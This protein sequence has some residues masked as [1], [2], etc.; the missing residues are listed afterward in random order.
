M[1]CKP[2]KA[3]RKP[4]EC[5]TYCRR[6]TFKGGLGTKQ[7]S[8]RQRTRDHLTPLSRGGSKREW[9]I[10]CNKCNQLKANMP[11]DDWLSFIARYQKWWLDFK[12]HQDVLKCIAR[13]ASVDTAQ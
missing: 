3:L 11:L 12:T 7:Q 5:C 4:Q 1:S 10:C 8:N 6:Y 13:W 9:V 2:H